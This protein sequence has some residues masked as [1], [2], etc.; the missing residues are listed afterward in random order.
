[1]RFT[2][3]QALHQP[4]LLTTL[5]DAAEVEYQE[6]GWQC[7]VLDVGRGGPDDGESNDDDPM[8]ES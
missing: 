8:D 3:P 1:L 7:R 6:M 2:V 4:H 5:P